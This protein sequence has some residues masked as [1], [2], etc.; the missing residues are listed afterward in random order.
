MSAPGNPRGFDGAGIPLSR[1]RIG[2]QFFGVQ[3]NR[4]CQRRRRPAQDAFPLSRQTVVRWRGYNR[5]MENRLSSITLS[6]TG[7]LFLAGNAIWFRWFTTGAS[8]LHPVHTAGFVEN[9]CPANSTLQHGTV[10]GQ[11]EISEPR[12]VV[13]ARWRS[14]RRFLWLKYGGTAADA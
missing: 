11:P 13:H 5:L 8:S 1:A 7:T 2:P 14:A 3:G 4:A 12:A 6:W 10:D 9:D